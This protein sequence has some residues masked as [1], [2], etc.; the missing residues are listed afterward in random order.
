MSFLLN[1]FSRRPAPRDPEIP[2]LVILPTEM[3]ISSP[4]TRIMLI[5]TLFISPNWKFLI[6]YE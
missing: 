3:H 2:L 1:P 4:K 5:V 6:A